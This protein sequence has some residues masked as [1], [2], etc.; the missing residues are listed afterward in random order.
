M[1]KALRQITRFGFNKLGLVRIELHVFPHNPASMK[2]ARKNNF[3][4][5]GILRKSHKK[6]RRYLD[7][8]VFAKVK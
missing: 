1:T 7:E 5:E 8:Y 6:G 4:L 3:K 2:V